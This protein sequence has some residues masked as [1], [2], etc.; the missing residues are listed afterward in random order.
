M[1]ALPGRI[2]NAEISGYYRLMDAFVV[3]RIDSRVSALVTPLKPMEA[4]A[5]GRR[6]WSAACRR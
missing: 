5:S 6:S 3:P 4:M 1:V 2:P